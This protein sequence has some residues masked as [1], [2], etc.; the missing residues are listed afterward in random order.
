VNIYTFFIF[1]VIV[2]AIVSALL[3]SGRR[4]QEAA[5]AWIDAIKRKT[6][7]LW[8]PAGGELAWQAGTL[9]ALSSGA[10]EYAFRQAAAGYARDADAVLEVGG[11][12]R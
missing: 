5:A 1:E 3:V 11:D 8:S 6:E 12:G 9:A 2:D 7:P 10:F 4:P